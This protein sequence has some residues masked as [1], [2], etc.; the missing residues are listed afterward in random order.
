VTVGALRAH[1]LLVSYIFWSRKMG[2]L[3]SYFFAS[4]SFAFIFYHQCQC[5]APWRSSRKSREQDPMQ[6]HRLPARQ[7]PVELI[8]TNV[9]RWPRQARYLFVAGAATFCWLIIGLAA[10]LI[11]A[12]L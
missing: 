5:V 4:R 1:W 10:Y 3:P 2:W 9:P 12:A 7:S 6:V 8:A 11:R